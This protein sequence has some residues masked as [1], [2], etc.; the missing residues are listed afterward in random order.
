M[1][2]FIS[3]LGLLMIFEGL[4]YFCFPEKIKE[5][6]Q[7]L[8]EVPNISLRTIGFGLMVIGLLV[9]YLGSVIYADE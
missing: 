3:A 1:K 7:K 8:P 2:L 6:A 4:A 9:A 5:L